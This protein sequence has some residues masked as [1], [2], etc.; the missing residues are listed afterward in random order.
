MEEGMSSKRREEVDQLV[1]NESAIMT[2]MRRGCACS[3]HTLS[4]S[5]SHDV[6]YFMH[7]PMGKAQGGIPSAR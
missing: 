1:V 3:F 2:D 5:G 7:L 4:I 6:Q